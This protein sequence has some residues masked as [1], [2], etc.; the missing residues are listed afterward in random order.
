MAERRDVVVRGGLVDY[1]DIRISFAAGFCRNDGGEQC[2]RVERSKIVPECLDLGK[3]DLIVE[4][5]DSSKRWQESERA[6][7]SSKSLPRLCEIAPRMNA[8]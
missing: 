6:L 2:V 3:A 4:G 5:K 7:G 8:C 1:K